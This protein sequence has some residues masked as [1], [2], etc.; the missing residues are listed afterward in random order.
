MSD[1]NEE[2]R[3]QRIARYKEERRKQNSIRYERRLVQ[4]NLQLEPEQKRVA[5]RDANSSP[6]AEGPRLNRASRFRAA[7]TAGQ[8]AIKEV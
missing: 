1:A 7:A 2:A 6:V 5:V 8:D 3:A 4:N